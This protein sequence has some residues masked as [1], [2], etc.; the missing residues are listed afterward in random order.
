MTI[1]YFVS[2]TELSYFFNSHPGTCV[3]FWKNIFGTAN[4][5]HFI[6]NLPTLFKAFGPKRQP[7]SCF[8]N[9]KEVYDKLESSHGQLDRY[10]IILTST[11]LALEVRSRTEYL[12]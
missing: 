12:V 7:F 8:T 11:T 2:H 5:N 6:A 10:C 3:L 1:V 9:P 4:A